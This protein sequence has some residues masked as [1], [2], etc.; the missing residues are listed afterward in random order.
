MRKLITFFRNINRMWLLVAL[1]VVLGLAAAMLMSKYLKGRE[2][3]LEMEVKKRASGGATTDVVAAGMD[4]PRGTV[5]G[6]QNLTKR[7][8][9]ADLVT[10]E[11]VLVGDFERIEGGKST[12]PIK[13][14]WPLRMADVTEKAK[15]FAEGLEEGLRAITIE[16]D[17]INSMAQMVKPGNMVDLMLIVPDKND[18][19]GGH[20]AVLV[21]EMVKVLATGQSVS[22][23]A[24]KKSGSSMNQGDYGGSAGNAQRYSNFTFEVTPQDAAR[25]ALAQQVG[26]IR[27]V[28]RGNEDSTTASLA[29]IDTK[30]LLNTGVN[31]VKT[32]STPKVSAVEYIIGGKGGAGAVNINIPS[33]FPP[34]VGDR[35]PA[36]GAE[37]ARAVYPPGLEALMPPPTGAANVQPRP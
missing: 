12:R 29:G 7:E 33:L 32:S 18:P 8:I 36:T 17:E 30:T 25:I 14:G 13:A 19:D 21:L 35:R 5:L 37:A 23:G 11:M 26:K 15:G 2:Q 31:A 1:A 3:E 6:T 34:S 27:A 16:V 10:E 4:I 9:R 20:R 22:P 24:G 28:L